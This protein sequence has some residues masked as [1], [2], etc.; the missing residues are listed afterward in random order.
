MK[1]YIKSLYNY[2]A[3][4]LEDM[5]EIV[6]KEELEE[7]LQNDIKATLLENRAFTEAST[8]EKGDVVVLSIKSELPRFN[9]PE[10]TLTVGLNLFNKEFEEKLLGHGVNEAFTV[11]VNGGEAAVV[12]KGC[13]RLSVPELDD[14]FVKALGIGNVETVSQYTA[15]L[16]E[17]YLNFYQENY[18]SWYAEQLFAEVCDK[19]DLYIDPEEFEQSYAVWKRLQAEEREFHNMSI[20]ENYEGEQEEMERQ[21]VLNI[22]QIYSVYCLLSGEDYRAFAFALS[23]TER[24]GS[25][26]NKVMK[27]LENYLKDKVIIKLEEK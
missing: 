26:R 9:K 17:K 13:K 6:T 4:P 18:V 19:S 16:T 3:L 24:L 12:I 27:P 11:A 14:A 15:Y 7:S 25:I 10:I 8:V 5:T 20:L 22:L 1:S 23:D 2:M 21:D